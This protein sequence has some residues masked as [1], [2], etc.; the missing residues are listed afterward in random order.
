MT[1]K[2][3]GPQ[4]RREPHAKGLCDTHYR[5]VKKGKP[6]TAINVAKTK[7]RGMRRSKYQ[8]LSEATGKYSRV[9]CAFK[10]CVKG[11]YAKDYCHGHYQQLRSKKNLA[12]LAPLR[13]PNLFM[14]PLRSKKPNGYDNL[15]L[16]HIFPDFP[17]EPSQEA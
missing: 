15:S 17:D 11:A 3:Q 16:S 8:K 7:K 2:C 5:Q 4:C 1:T 13:K 12:P 10:G 14:A 6:T 9:R